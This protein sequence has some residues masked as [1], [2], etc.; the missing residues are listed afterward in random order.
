M[1]NFSAFRLNESEN[2]GVPTFLLLSHRHTSFWVLSL[3]SRSR[4]KTLDLPCTSLQTSLFAYFCLVEKH[5]CI[6]VGPV[7]GNSV[8]CCDQGWE[9]WG[10][11]RP[12]RW[13][14][15][16]HKTQ[17]RGPASKVTA[18]GREEA[19]WGQGQRKTPARNG[20]GPL[21]GWLSWFSLH[22]HTW[23]TVSHR[24][25]GLHVNIYVTTDCLPGEWEP[26]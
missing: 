10:K 5:L 22:R 9:S 18:E 1:F 26:G 25:Q 17:D 15:S 8:S 16:V 19:R 13:T 24:R 23:I 21:V 20:L 3:C 2:N 11:E 7:L 4:A 14:G 6:F 12:C